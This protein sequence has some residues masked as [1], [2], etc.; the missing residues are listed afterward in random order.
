ML[1]VNLAGREFKVEIFVAVKKKKN[2]A[3]YSIIF[4]LF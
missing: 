3:S 1:E 4:L 2:M